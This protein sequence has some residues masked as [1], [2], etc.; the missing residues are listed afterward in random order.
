MYLKA[1]L[2]LVYLLFST[3][4]FAQKNTGTPKSKPPK[5]SFFE[6]K[7][8]AL[9]SITLTSL[10]NHK[11]IINHAIEDQSYLTLAEHIN[12]SSPEALFLKAYAYAQA[13][14]F[15]Q[16]LPLLKNLDTQLPYLKDEI[17]YIQ[18]QAILNLYLDES[19]AEEFTEAEK[20]KQYQKAFDWLEKIS[21]QDPRLYTEKIRFEAI[22]QRKLKNGKQS[23]SLYQWLLQ[24]TPQEDH[25]PVY[26]GQALTYADLEQP[27][28][29]ID[30]LKKLDIEYPLSQSNQKA[31]ELQ[32]K[33]F[34]LDDQWKVLWEKRSHT[35]LI[36]RLEKIADQK[37]YSVLVTECTRVQEANDIKQWNEKDKCAFYYYLGLGL[38]KS[39]KPK[40]AL[41]ALTT[42]ITQCEKTKQAVGAWALFLAGKIASK[43]DLDDDADVFFEKLLTIYP[44]HRLS[45]DASTYLIRHTINKDRDPKSGELKEKSNLKKAIQYVK[46]AVNAQPEGDMVSEALSFAFTEAMRRN[47]LKSAKELITLGEELTAVDFQEHEAGRLLY[48]K[49]RLLALDKKEAQAKKTYQ[50]VMTSA[51]MTWYALM[52]YNRLYEYDQKLAKKAFSQWRN[53]KE[54]KISLPSIH[55]Q[56][57]H[58][59]FPNDQQ[60][61]LVMK[62]AYWYRVGMSKQFK[63]IL[64]DLTSTS[65]LKHIRADLLLF[66]A[67]IL[68][69]LKDYPSSHNI[70][71]RQLWEYRFVA[72]HHH[73]LK[74]WKLAFPNPFKE[75]V[76]LAAKE[77]AVESEFIWG[78]MREESG[79]ITTIKSHANAYGLLQLILPTAQSMK[80][81]KEKAVTAQ[82]L[83][84]PS[85]NIPLGARYLANVKKQCD[86][87][88]ALVPAGYNAGAGALKKWLA[89]RGDLPLDLFVETIPYE[90]A[91]WYLKRVVSSWIT[92]KTIYH[93]DQ[94]YPW[95]IIPQKIR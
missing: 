77:T 18:A 36:T 94:E 51:P 93:Q 65:T 31:K 23:L 66:E 75:Q 79:F 82:T 10:A 47:D 24:H 49:A 7:A 90:E 63:R 37:Q 12:Q 50:Q 34:A 27:E 28:K 55:D 54:K 83:S 4:A 30:C 48:W 80:K 61:N 41:A 78:I 52:A 91:R 40:E 16:A 68:D 33:L 35:E 89:L 70:L 14:G 46:L 39:K 38:D 53:H 56:D 67:W 19:K 2:L 15:D 81:P 26:L 6:I 21:N 60:Q 64:D 43:I 45:D 73:T 95:P 3:L 87:P 32:D 58:F 92:Y 76:D 9:E 25:A 59:K 11:P 44:T 17:Y 84:I 71:R 13:K 72:P 62:A 86:C 1:L 29:A 5:L 74:Y 8:K 57:W 42:A 88:W 69:K 20:K 85:V 22:L